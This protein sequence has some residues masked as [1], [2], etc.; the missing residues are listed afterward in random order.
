MFSL[1]SQTVMVRRVDPGWRTSSKICAMA[2]SKKGQFVRCSAVAWPLEAG[3]AP[4]WTRWKSFRK[5]VP[6]MNPDRNCEAVRIKIGKLEKELEAMGDSE[7]PI[8]DYLKTE[9]EKARIAA[10]RRL[11]NVD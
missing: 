1:V 10:K 4:M 11:V 8:V 9:L 2:F 3:S 6:H 5:Q 7:G